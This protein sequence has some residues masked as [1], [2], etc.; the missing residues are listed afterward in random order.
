MAVIVED[1]KATVDL[2]SL[3]NE[4]KKQ[5]LPVYARPCIIRLV[6]SIEM[7]GVFIFSRRPTIVSHYSYS[8]FYFRNI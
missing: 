3:P 7:T 4:M 8:I 2:N 5:G 1:Q 6:K